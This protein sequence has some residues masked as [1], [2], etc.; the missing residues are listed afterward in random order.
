MGSCFFIGHRE[1]SALI[2]PYIKSAV[3]KLIQE[4]KTRDFYVGGYGSFD[5]LSGKAVLQ[6]KKQFPAI[7]LYRVLPYHPA[8]HRIETQDGFDG[9]YYPDGMEYVPRRYAIS[10]A[11]RAMIDQ[12]TFLIAYVWHPASNAGKLLDYARSREKKGL[13]RIINLADME[14]VPK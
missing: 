4:E 8:D 10:R 11:N 14:G 5:Q 9:T 13:I 1:A 2:L 6:L 3:E 7:R 12:S